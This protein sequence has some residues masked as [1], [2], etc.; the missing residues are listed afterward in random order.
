MFCVQLVHESRV[1]KQN[2]PQTTPLSDEEMVVY[3][4][5]TELGP[6][7]VM[8]AATIAGR[9][10]G[11]QKTG[12]SPRRIPTGLIFGFFGIILILPLIIYVDGFT[13]W[14]LNHWKQPHPAH[15]LLEVLKT[16]PPA[17]LRVAD[18]LSA[19]L[20]APLT[21]EMFFRGLLQTVIRGALRNSWIAIALSAAAFALVHHWWTWPQIFFLGFCLGYAYERTGNLWVSITIHALFNLTSIWLFTH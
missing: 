4:A 11:I 3:S 18:V 7:V 16:N 20:I 21:E 17:W 6:F 19:G 1:K 14:M 8:I 10:D 12:L 2:L 5:A 9:P 15:E 13:E